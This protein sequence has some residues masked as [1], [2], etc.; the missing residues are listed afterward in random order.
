LVPNTDHVNHA[1]VAAAM[2]RIS[3]RA[4]TLSGDSVRWD[5]LQADR[6]AGRP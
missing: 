5:V 6:D 4:R 2:A 1:D 3:A